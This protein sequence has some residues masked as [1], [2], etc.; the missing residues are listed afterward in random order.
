PG[1]QI[2]VGDRGAVRFEFPTGW[3]VRHDKKDTLTLH[4]RPPPKDQVRISLTVF[5]LPPV[6]GGW[7]QLPLE[8]LFRSVAAED[9]ADKAR[10]ANKKPKPGEAIPDESVPALTPEQLDV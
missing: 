10:K 2:F 1:N 9:A 4:D 7:S 5:H 8:G 6:K 3:V